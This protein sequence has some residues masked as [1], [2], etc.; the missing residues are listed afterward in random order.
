[1]SS[2]QPAAFGPEWAIGMGLS[3]IPLGPDK[4]PIISRWKPYQAQLPSLDE[5]KNWN[6]TLHPA[7]WAIVTGA[8]SGLV[9]LDFDGQ[10]GIDTMRKLGINPHRR[11]PSGGYHAHFLHPGWHVQTLNSKT[12]KELGAR[13]PGLDIRADGGYCAFTG[14]SRTGKYEWLCEDPQ[15][16][17]LDILPQELR[18]FLGL[19]SPP[20][21]NGHESGKPNGKVHSS[22]SNGRVAAD[23]LI[24]KA[25]EHIASEGRNNAGFGLACQLRDNGYSEAEAIGA[26]QDYRA[27]AGSTNT[28]GQ[29]EPYTEAEMLKTLEEV[30]KTPAREPWK[31]NGGGKDTHGTASAAAIAR[32]GDAP[33]PKPSWKSKL[34]LNDN[35]TPKVLLANAITALRHAPE[36]RG[37]LAYNEFSSSVVALNAPPWQSNAVSIKWSDHE[38]RLATNWLQH[39]GVFVNDDVAGKAVQVVAKDRRF[40]PVRDYLDAL[41]WDGTKRIDTWLSLYLGVDASVYTHSVGARWL[42][43]AVARIYSPGTKADCCLVLEGGQGIFKSQALEALAGGRPYF[44]DELSDLGSKDAAMQL[45]GVWIIEIAEL[46]SLLRSEAGRIKAFMSRSADRFRPPYGK[47]LAEYPRQCVFAGSVNLDTYLKDETGARRFWPVACTYIRLAELK[48]DRD[49]LWAEAVVAYSQQHRKWWLDS[50]DLIRLAEEEQTA[51]YDADP[52][53]AKIAEFISPL[54]D[55]SVPEILERCIGRPRDQWTRGDS[56]RVG[57]CLVFRKWRKYRTVAKDPKEKREWRYRSPQLT[58][59]F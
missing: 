35:G 9:V 33:N 40:H 56:M 12:K 5:I 26:M 34:I 41:K 36:F 53:D 6:K 16:Y 13:W 47:H 52:W 1:M 21:P 39:S 24:R 58:L 45:Q 19:L 43:S 22:P 38:D 8:I 50:P 25:V 44:T 54:D 42:I 46:E 37:V 59:G 27:R 29:S 51:R 20:K 2:P 32:S 28:K 7:S 14:R 4:K 10:A 55:T 57:N 18:E 17:K 48:R 31:T 49:Q 11:T 23:V 3:I 15:P 30:Y